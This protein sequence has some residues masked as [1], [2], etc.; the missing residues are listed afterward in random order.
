[1]K[2]RTK[3][4]EVEARQLTQE[5]REEI[6][7]WLNGGLSGGAFFKETLSAWYYDGG[8]ELYLKNSQTERMVAFEGDWIV[9]GKAGVL[10]VV[11]PEAFKL[12]YEPIPEPRSGLYQC[13]ECDTQGA[14]NT[15]ASG[16]VEGKHQCDVCFSEGKEHTL[17]KAE[18]D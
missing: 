10:K 11:K 15:W 5:N 18:K 1:M 7:K 2:Y 17:V 16:A 6:S 13:S 12:T 3:P 9:C 4:V 14:W 8:T